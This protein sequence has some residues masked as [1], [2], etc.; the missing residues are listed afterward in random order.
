MNKGRYLVGRTAMT[1]SLWKRTDL[2]TLLVQP[3]AVA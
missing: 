3:L 2:A 1:A